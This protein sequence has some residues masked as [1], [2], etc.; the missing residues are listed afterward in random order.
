MTSQVS[1]VW[2]SRDEDCISVEMDDGSRF[3]YWQRKNGEIVRQHER[4]DKPNELPAVLR[5]LG[6]TI[7]TNA[8]GDLIQK[9]QGHPANGRNKRA[10][11]MARL[12]KEHRAYEAEK[13]VQRVR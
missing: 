7:M 10:G 13:E 1:H 4:S 6:Q 3:V 5:V 11:R 2:V 8:W 9:Y 12:Y